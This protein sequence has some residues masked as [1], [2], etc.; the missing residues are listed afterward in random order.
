MNYIPLHLKYRPK[1]LADLV[2]QT[3]IATTMTHALIQR[4]IAPAYL[5]SGQRGTGKTSTARIL[6]KSLNCLSSEHPTPTPCGQCAMCQAISS[7]T[8]LDVIELDA[9][10]NNGVEEVRELINHSQFRPVQGR[11]KV[12]IIDECHALS[13]SATQALLKTLEEPPPNVVFILC[14][15]EAQKLGETII[16]R[17]QRYPFSPLSAEHLVNHLQQVAQQEKMSITD[18]AL[19]LIASYA[20]GGVRDALTLLDQARL[21]ADSITAKHIYD[22]AGQVDED[23]LYQIVESIIEQNPEKLLKTLRNLHHKEPLS[24]INNLLG[25]YTNLILAQSQ[26]QEKLGTVSSTM[27]QSLKA[28]SLSPQKALEQQQYL[29][30]CETQIKFSRMPQLM[31]ETVLLGLLKTPENT[32]S[33]VSTPQPIN[34]E[35]IW[36]EVIQQSQPTIKAILT[37]HSQLIGIKDDIVTISVKSNPLKLLLTHSISQLTKTFESILHSAVVIKLIP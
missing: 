37:Q 2:G 31:L 6:A 3:A 27:W 25:F 22:L 1:T 21:L 16:S 32:H 24:L 13:H 10:S 4:R 17:C 30:S 28:F 34:S 14:T 11:Y 19:R 36:Q 35:Q 5:L 8:A 15:T 29:R 9:A 18:D 7:G 23:D 20:Q 26:A 12:W 33:T